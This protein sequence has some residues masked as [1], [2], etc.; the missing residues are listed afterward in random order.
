MPGTSTSA[1][2]VQ[3]PDAPEALSPVFQAWDAGAAALLVSGRSLYDLTCHEGRLRTLLEV[4]RRD[5]RR[6]GLHVVTYSLAAGLDYDAPRV[7]DARDRQTIEQVLR[8]HSLLDVP[9]DQHEVTAVIRG[10]SSLCRTPAGALRWV[11]GEP[12]R[13]AFL[14]EFAE[15]LAPGTLTNGTQTD[16]QLVAIELA[17]LTAQSLALR[18]S[19]HLVVFHGRDGLVDPL[20]AEV[21][22]AVAL[23][24][25]DEAEKL[26][27]L[28]VAREL[29][30][31][32]TFEDDLA[33]ETVA[34]LCT[35]TP[36]RSLEAL[37][38]AGE[39][40]RRPITARDLTARKS[41]DVQQLSEGTLEMLDSSRVRGLELHG[42]NIASVQRLM[43]RFGDALLRGDPSMPGAVLLA[44]APGCGKTDLALIAAV[45]AAVSAYEMH[46]PKAGIVG[47]TERRTRLQQRLLAQFVPNLAFIDE[48]TEAFPMERSDF[49]G[50]SG[51]SRAVMA[52]L[53]T[54]LSDEA[55]RG[56]SMLVSTT[57]CLWR[58]SSAMLSRFVVI[59]VLF[60]LAN[61]YPDIVVTTAARVAPDARLDP[62][63]ARVAQAA[64]LFHD[65]GASPRDIRRALGHARLMK[66]A[67]TADTVLFAAEDQCGSTS[68]TSSIYA[69]LWAVRCCTQKSLFPWADSP[70]SY[71]FPAHLEGVIDPVNGDKNE[72]ELRKRIEELRPYANV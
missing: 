44:G 37:M 10:I 53:L 19:G 5:A 51:A 3:G 16:A 69:D 28:G 17:H 48:I 26:E 59:P 60:P 64:R 52:S 21:L 41:A 58:V 68:R 33:P 47:E 4:F 50:D 70:A 72:D 8:A 11:S 36:N 14:F 9:R 23:P 30:P 32:A 1:T 35:H 49:D 20:V 25:P 42:R 15:H 6:R 7:A 63:D 40:S 31:G 34:H 2:V 18:N 66:G 57:N 67:I 56:R 61:D 62:A 24:Q 55:R 71:P 43:E 39:A 29:Y 38:R 12:A 13:F 45:R 54:A 65:K 27:F 22:H 46:S